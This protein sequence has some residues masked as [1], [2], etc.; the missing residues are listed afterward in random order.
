MDN[1]SEADTCQVDAGG[2][3]AGDAAEA[4]AAAKREV[5]GKEWAA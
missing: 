4:A 5:F 2:E 3:D 1:G